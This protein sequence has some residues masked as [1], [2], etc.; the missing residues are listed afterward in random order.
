MK[1][2]VMGDFNFPCYHPQDSTDSENCILRFF[3]EYRLCQLAKQP[4]CQES[5]LDLILV[6][7]HF[8][9]SFI[10]YL[11]P[12]GG[13]DHTVQ[14]LTLENDQPAVTN[15]KLHTS[16]DVD[17]L[18]VLLSQIVW[19]S[20]FVWCLSV[21]DFVGQFDSVLQDAISRITKTIYC[22]RRTRLQ[23]HVVS[24]LRTKKRA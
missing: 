8:V 13:S 18:G 1:L 10:T 3:S 6:S 5:F 15:K 20:V 14:L 22:L 7:P 9:N 2:I 4:S 19:D 11:P 23:K 12:I 17:L 21:D 16:V 24:L